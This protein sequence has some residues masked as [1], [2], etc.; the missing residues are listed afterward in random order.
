MS[1][2]VNFKFNFARLPK[3]SKLTPLTDLVPL[4]VDLPV[5]VPCDE[6]G[7][8]LAAKVA[9]R[10]LGARVAVLALQVPRHYALLHHPDSQG[11]QMSILEVSG[12]SSS[13]SKNN[14]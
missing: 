7:A 9:A 13:F 12:L 11:C 6:D 8:E 2:K 4:G 3:F 14:H 5:L 10:R 1:K